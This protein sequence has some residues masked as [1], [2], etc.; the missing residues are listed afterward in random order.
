[1]HKLAFKAAEASQCA[2]EQG[3]FWEIHDSM[4][5]DQKTLD[6]PES[7]AESIHLDVAQFKTCMNSDKYADAIRRDMAL[8]AKLGVSGTPSFLLARAD[9]DNPSKVK[10]LQ[11]L[12]GARPF[13]AFK[14][15]LDQVLKG[16]EQ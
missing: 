3:K 5:A 12:R 10:G 4:M 8:A 2:R 7:Y 15:V 11:L 13:A 14:Q 9:P 16:E 6:A 1:M